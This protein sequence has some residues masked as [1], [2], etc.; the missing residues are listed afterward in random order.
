MTNNEKRAIE[1][2]M[3]E[4]DSPAKSNGFAFYG[5]IN[6]LVNSGIYKPVPHSESEQIDKIKEG[7]A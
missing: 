3:N 5:L 6:A 2:L 4:S 7:V 1:L